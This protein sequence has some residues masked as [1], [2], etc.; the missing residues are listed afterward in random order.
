MLDYGFS[1][2]WDELSE[3]LKEEKIDEYIKYLEANGEKETDRI[4]A[5]KYI[6]RHFPVYF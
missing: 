2:D 4:D 5:E 6:K 3:D 1:L